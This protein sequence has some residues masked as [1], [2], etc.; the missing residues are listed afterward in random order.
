MPQQAY[1]VDEI[2]QRIQQ[3]L[4]GQYGTRADDAW[5]Y[6]IYRATCDTLRQ[7]LGEA[8]AQSGIRAAKKRRLYLLSFEYMPGKL[9]RQNAQ[10]LGILPLLKKALHQLGHRL[11]ALERTEREISLGHGALGTISFD[12]LLSAAN[13]GISL[14]GYGLR[15]KN[16]RLKQTL[17]NGTQVEEPDNWVS[18]K[19]PWEH[20]KAYFHTIP[21]QGSAVKAIPYDIPVVG[22]GASQINTL[23]IWRA[24]AL[25]DIDFQLFSE[26]DFSAAYERINAAHAIVEFLYPNE[27]TERGQ[28]LRLM[29]EVFFATATMRD[30]FRTY[31]KDGK[32]RSIQAFP[33]HVHIHL[34]E[35]QTGFTIVACVHALTEDYGLSFSQALRM[36]REVFSYTNFSVQA[37]SFEQWTRAQ[38]ER[39]CPHWIPTLEKMQLFFATEDES[40]VAEVQTVYDGQSL[41][42]IALA[43]R[44]AHTITFLT[45]AHARSFSNLLSPKKGV[46]FAGR[47]QPVRMGISLHR[48]LRTTNPPLY[49]F[50][51]TLSGKESVEGEED[52]VLAALTHCASDE[53]VGKALAA[54]KQE[55]KKRVA[56]E[57]Y[58]RKGIEINPYSVYDMQLGVIHESKRQLLNALCLAMKYFQLVEQPQADVPEVTYFFSGKAA[59]NYYAAKEILH[60]INALANRINHDPQIREKMMVV[61]IED[62]NMSRIQALLPACDTYENL[63]FAEKEPCGTTV[64]KAMVNGAVPCTS[65]TGIGYDLARQKELACYAFGPTIDEIFPRPVRRGKFGYI[66]ESQ[67]AVRALLERLLR[68]SRRVIDYDFHRLY[69]LLVRY[70]DSFSVLED[71]LSYRTVRMQMEMDYFDAL[72]WNRKSLHNIAGSAEFSMQT[73]LQIY[74][75]TVWNAP[76]T[77]VNQSAQK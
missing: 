58:A 14:M 46:P 30:I 56:R 42:L 6:E 39:V 41:H 77:P 50:L 31:H 60:F 62:Y 1:T 45:E 5:N 51:S 13:S 68:C 26:G 4:Y 74:R 43:L 37:E 18:N 64:M 19:N 48:W 22:Y 16:G 66:L 9:L 10:C 70:D 71:L 76:G 49:D 40:G 36:T 27:T 35:V 2:A 11:S 75:D 52:A 24:E 7:M 55:H 44:M 67:D 23:R 38:L 8:W 21:L 47:L 61:F 54:V 3:N 12:E 33:A 20:E 59:P 28:Y 15:Y 25:E 32:E 17:V 65:R 53:S 29:Q 69:E 34:N 73:T 57:V 63:G 72:I